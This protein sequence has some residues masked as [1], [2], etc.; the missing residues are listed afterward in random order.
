MRR[1]AAFYFFALALT[2]CDRV[3]TPKALEVADTV[4]GG[5]WRDWTAYAI[6]SANEGNFYDVWKRLGNDGT[7]SVLN[8]GASDQ[9]HAAVI[10]RVF[11]PPGGGGAPVSRR[12][13]VAWTE[14]LS[15]GLL[16]VTQT[17][18]NEHGSI[19]SQIDDDPLGPRPVLVAPRTHFE[20]W[21][22]PGSG[23]VD[24]DR[25]ATPAERCPFP[26]GHDEANTAAVPV[27]LTCEVGTYL[28]Q[29]HA[30]LVRRLDP[31]DKRMPDPFPRHQIIVAQQQVK[32]I[33]FIV[34]CPEGDP[35][36][37]TPD[38]TRYTN[39]CGNYPFPFWRRNHLFAS[40]L[41]VDVAQM[42]CDKNVFPMLCGRTLRTGTWPRPAGPRMI[43][44]TLSYPDGTVKERGADSALM[45][46]TDHM[47]LVMCSAYDVFYGGRRQC[48]VPEIALPKWQSFY[49]MLVL[50][51]EEGPR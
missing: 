17:S 34:H 38:F 33:R 32:G 25:M 37:M 50:D 7:I 24:I 8:N 45:A 47:F 48:L 40:S 13:L 35:N 44:W 19:T 51:I 5:L 31:A 42:K 39:A 18:P 36:R 43:R 49:G 12:S 11:V 15:Y 28:V 6:Q 16:A 14:N 27:M 22:I 23:T 3:S 20:D 1:H 4:E 2:A 41:G 21:W 46:D 9:L 26:D 29:A 30:E 10:E